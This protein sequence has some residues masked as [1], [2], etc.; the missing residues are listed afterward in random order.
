MTARNLLPMVAILVSRSITNL[1]GLW[2]MCA[3]SAH[4]VATNALREIF[5]PYPPPSRR[6]LMLMLKNTHEI[7]E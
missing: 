6:T 1:T 4:E 2:S 5:A 3:A 7:Y